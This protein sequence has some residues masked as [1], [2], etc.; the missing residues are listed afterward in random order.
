MSSAVLDGSDAV[1]LSAETAIGDY[2]ARTVQAMAA[3]CY[4][5][6]QSPGYGRGP[7][8][9]F[10]EDRAR[11]ASATAQACVDAATNLGLRAIVAFTESGTTARLISKYRP[12]ADIYAYTPVVRTYRRMALYAG[13]TPLLIDR[14]ESTDAM[15]AHAE[16][17][18]LAAQIVHVGEGVVMAAGIP[19]N[20]EASTNLMKLHSV[21]S[22]TRGAPGG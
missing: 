22:T 18:L 8:I 19:P 10:L 21:G 3:I 14:V 2:P 1:M 16:K 9:E 11:F 12:R 15:I 4:E 20:E 13:V 5:A 6:E 7:E 17:S